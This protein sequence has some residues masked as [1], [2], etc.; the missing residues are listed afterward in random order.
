MSRVQLTFNLPGLASHY[1]K[2][3]TIMWSRYKSLLLSGTLIAGA[4]GFATA[5]DQPGAPGSSD[6]QQ[7]IVE[8][9]ASG[10]RSIPNSVTAQHRYRIL[11]T[12][13]TVADDRG[14]YGDFC[15]YG[16]W[17]GKSYAGHN[18]LPAGYWVYVAPTWYIYKD[19]E[20]STPMPSRGPR[21][22]GP[23]QA[24]GAP[25]TWPNAGDIPTAWASQTPDGQPE[26][27]ELTYDAPIRPV[28]VSVYET[29]NPGAVTRV[30]G[31]DDKGAEVELWSGADPTPA[32][33]D[34]GI[35]VIPV[36]PEFDLTRVRIYIDSPKVQGWNEIDAVGLLDAAGTTHWAASATASSTY[37]DVSSGI[38]IIELEGVEERRSGVPARFND[39][40][41][42]LELQ[43]VPNA[44][45]R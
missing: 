32:G 39:A 28:A 44:R 22:W 43:A 23:E 45:V 10:R 17:N 27:L 33:K 29:F 12:T 30:T 20:T 37:A 9:T 34:K 26:W 18:D 24:T 38:N 8:I 41:D 1:A 6:A 14:S 15:D 25:N 36:H 13:L 16:Y 40:S 19:T 3:S 31:Y 21:N 42:K 7:R 5:E 35:S 2:W 11:L 4:V